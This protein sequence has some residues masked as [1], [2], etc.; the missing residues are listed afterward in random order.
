MHRTAFDVGTGAHL[1]E[2]V[3]APAK[4]S[5]RLLIELHVDV[6]QQRIHMRADWDGEVIL[7]P[8]TRLA[9]RATPWTP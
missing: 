9:Q 8:W 2:V 7:R 6:A 1:V 4:L 3:E 5:R